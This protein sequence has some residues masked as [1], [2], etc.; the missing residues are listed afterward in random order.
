MANAVRVPE[1]RRRALFT[2]AEQLA[3]HI[4][5]HLTFVTTWATLA[6]SRCSHTRCEF[7]EE[8]AMAH[9]RL[10]LSTTTRPSRT[11]RAN[12]IRRRRGPLRRRLILTV[13]ALAILLLALGGWPFRPSGR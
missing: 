2:A 12:V 4:H 13:L 10:V 5:V 11:A 8:E 7:S 1:L 9:S 6:T 3:F